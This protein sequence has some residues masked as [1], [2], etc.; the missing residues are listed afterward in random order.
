MFSSK[1]M[2]HLDLLPLEPQ[3]QFIIGTSKPT[4]H[5]YHNGNS[6][7]EFYE[8]E[9]QTFVGEAENMSLSR[10][11]IRGSHHHSA[12][13][14][15]LSRL[16]NLFLHQPVSLQG[17]HMSHLQALLDEVK[18]P[19]SK[20][21]TACA[22]RKRLSA[23]DLERLPHKWS[24]A[25][26]PTQQPCLVITHPSL[27]RC[28][29]IKR[30]EGAVHWQA[31]FKCRFHEGK[32]QEDDAISFTCDPKQVRQ[33]EKLRMDF[34]SCPW[35]QPLT[36]APTFEPLGKKL[37]MVL[38]REGIVVFPM[39]QQA[40]EPYRLQVRNYLAK[41]MQWPQAEWLDR[42]PLMNQVHQQK[43]L[44]EPLTLELLRRYPKQAFSTHIPSVHGRTGYG[45]YSLEMKG[46]ATAIA[47]IVSA[48]LS[49]PKS[50]DQAVLSFTTSEIIVKC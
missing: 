46:L 33:Y 43:Q 36:H 25:V 23:E 5:F 4:V 17:Y 22:L 30:R 34:P 8:V 10:A 41:V 11:V 37:R 3:H 27:V 28:D 49:Q 13:F 6:Q 40:M 16:K 18:N 32:I 48:I 2:S 47:P 45:F 14:N 7:H 29:T 35:P 20:N 12:F 21:A 26:V 1:D 15:E 42:V 38:E 31:L 44:K 24:F 19:A 50:S 39:S 9:V